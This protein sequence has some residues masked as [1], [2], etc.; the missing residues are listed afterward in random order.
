M[1]AHF[2]KLCTALLLKSRQLLPTFFKHD[3]KDDSLQVGLYELTQP[4]GRERLVTYEADR[5]SGFNANVSYQNA[6]GS[7]YMFR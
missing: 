6:Q 5:D 7:G 4:D 1:E 3:S 2:L